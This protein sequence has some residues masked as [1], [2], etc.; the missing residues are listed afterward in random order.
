MKKNAM[1]LLLGK[2]LDGNATVAL[3]EMYWPKVVAMTRF[4]FEKSKNYTTFATLFIMSLVSFIGVIASLIIA[5][6]ELELTMFFSGVTIFASVFSVLI[7][8]S[9]KSRSRNEVRVFDTNCYKLRR[10]IEDFVNI[11]DTGKSLITDWR[12]SREITEH[13]RMSIINLAYAI[14]KAEIRGDSDLAARYRERLNES[15]N[16]CLRFNIIDNPKY[17]PFYDEANAI[18]K[19]EE[20]NK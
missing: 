19:E 13:G 17:H 18:I 3:T 1:E 2:L 8:F 9:F 11:R 10:L 7:Y 6:I 12:F 15:V 4:S 5:P 14:R 20:K 16:L